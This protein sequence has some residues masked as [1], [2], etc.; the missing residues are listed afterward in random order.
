MTRKTALTRERVIRVAIRYAD[1]N[2]IERLNM[3]TLAGELD[4][5]VMSIYH[6]V[7]NKDDLLDAMVESVA[8]E[9]VIPDARA[10]WREA[11]MEIAVSAYRVFLKHAWVAAIWSK[12]SLGPARLAHMESILRVLREGGFS[13]EL[14]CQAYHAITMH[15]VGFTLQALDFPLESKDLKNAA[16]EF[17][18]TVEDPEAI[19]YFVE[20]VRHHIE[21]PEPGNEFALMLDMILD[22]FERNLGTE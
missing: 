15:A 21:H 4:A 1:K 19:P 18:A 20:H 3:R 9:I 10:P 2:G 12:R 17:L 16:T 7:K 5:G 14:A 8:A 22:G 13:V 6:Y 11:V